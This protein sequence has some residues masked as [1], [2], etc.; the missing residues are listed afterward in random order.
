MAESGSSSSLHIPPPK[1][2]KITAMQQ[3]APMPSSHQ[4]MLTCRG[5]SVSILSSLCLFSVFVV[6]MLFGHFCGQMSFSGLDLDMQKTKVTPY[7]D[8]DRPLRT[9]GFSTG[10]SLNQSGHR[11]VAIRQKA[12]L[13]REQKLEQ[14]LA[15]ARY[16]IRR[17]AASKLKLSAATLLNGDDFVPS[18]VIYRNPAAFYQSHKEMEKRFRVW[19]YK[20]G[21]A[22]IFHVGPMRDIYSI[23]GQLIDEL[24]SEKS[25]F[26]AREPEEAT[27]FFVPVSIVFIIKYIYGSPCVDYSRERLQNVVKDYIHRISERYPYWNRSSGADHFMVSCHDW[28]P[29]VSANDP[30][31]FKHFIRGLCNAN[32]SEGFEITRDVSLPEVHIH[33]KNLD[34]PRLGQPPN[35]R[36]IFAFF[37][38]GDHGEV[39]KILFKHWKN[40]DTD[41]QVHEY[42]PKTA[43]YSKLMGESKF[44]L[45][46]SGWEVASPRVVESIHAGCIPVIISDN[47]VLPFSDVLDWSRFSVHIPS[48]KIPEMKKILQA[49]SEEEYLAMQK[50]VIQVQRHFTLNRPAKPYDVIHMV[51]HSVWLR[52]LNI[53]LPL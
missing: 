51:L 5:C 4:K 33:N 21:E 11:M 49:I 6:F 20:E 1:S 19:T 45:C 13:S 46:P 38:G 18:G 43:N 27:A 7:D 23:E 28:A 15:R 41:I 35:K 50:R 8:Q 39:R 9:G 40:K 3:T 14:G 52:R 37:A 44:C 2:Q 12:K 22:P 17:S 48:S 30:E 16:S 26:L 31:L 34:I 24:E 53:R 47:Y 29:E 10:F 32:T 42:L 36:L 25:K